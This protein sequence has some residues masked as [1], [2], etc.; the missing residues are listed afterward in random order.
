MIKISNISFSNFRQYREIN[1]SFKSNDTNLFV[2]KAKNGTGK[3]T[4]LNGVLWCLYGKEYYSSSKEGL[5]ILNDSVVEKSIP[6]DRPMVKVCITLDLDDS[7]VE[8][9]RQQS[10]LVKPDYSSSTKKVAE[11]GRSELFVTVHT[12]NNKE[13]ELIGEDANLFVRRYFDESIFNY[14]FFDGENLH[15]FFDNNEDIKKSIFQISQVNLLEEAARHTKQLADDLSKEANKDSIGANNLYS[16]QTYLIN[17]LNNA[18][19]SNAEIERNRPGLEAD[20][21]RL[22]EKMKKVGPAKLKIE[23]RNECLSK[24][25]K[26]TN[27][28]KEVNAKISDFIRKYLILFS[29]KNRINSLNEL[30]VRKEKEGTLPP[31]IDTAQINDILRKTEEHIQKCPLCNSIIGADQISYLKDLL[32]K[33][34]YSTKTGTLLKQIEVSIHS[35]QRKMQDYEMEKNEL[36]TK[37]RDLEKDLR[38]NTEKLDSIKQFLISND[39]G[40]EVE[41]INKLE[42]DYQNVDRKIQNNIKIKTINDEVIKTTSKEL[43][44][45]EEKIAKLEKEQNSKNILNKKAMLY[46]RLYTAFSDVRETI[47]NEVKKEIEASTWEHF[48]KMNWKKLSFSEINIDSEYNVFVK[49]SAGR[50]MTGS[51]GAT[52]RM[53]LAYSFTL[54]IHQA[55]GR[56]CPLLVDSPLGRSSDESREGI[57]KQLL[58]ISKNKQIIMLFTPDEYSEQ[59]ENVYR[60]NAL[61]RDLS[62]TDD[63]KE[64]SEIE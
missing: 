29:F 22:L 30:I 41:N 13:Q 11:A 64:I 39:F 6:S 21:A 49:N 20:R 17:T 48:S 23:E 33:Y 37:K 56:N 44:D 15:S 26:L 45:V 60:D 24:E 57:A 50:N 4:L 34:Q 7:Y 12:K 43:K 31:S 32:T 53:C 5:T 36:F 14:Y 19:A 42:E 47:M 28:L 46:R 38:E 61:I 16:S 1:I 58:L 63:E 51:L 25:K 35:F 59:V 9:S 3:T 55:S 2:L 8:I 54:A 27:E 10:F 62:L 18:R 52:E 40:S